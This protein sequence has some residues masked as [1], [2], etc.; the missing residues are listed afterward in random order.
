MDAAKTSGAT[1]RR[2]VLVAFDGSTSARLAARWAAREAA[3]S[4][5]PLQLAYVLRWPRP[6]L[7]GLRLPPAVLDPGQARRAASAVLDA[8]AAGCG[9]I[10]PQLDVRTELLTGGEVELLA[11]LAAG[12]HLLVLGACGQTAAPQVLLGSSAAELVRRVASSVVVVRDGDEVATPAHGHVVVGVDGSPG[13]AAALRFGFN[14]AARQGRV[15]VAVHA[16]SDLPL[17]AL[18]DPAGIDRVAAREDAAA[19]LAERLAAACRQEPQV[20]VRAVTTLDRPAHALLEQA[21][22]AALLVVGRHGRAAGREAPL[23]S[24]SHAV[25]HYASCPVAVVGPWGG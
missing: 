22:R 21:A 7:A 17:D 8:A 2:P 13:S 3:S 23:G 20:K 10:A 24:V 18:G 6:E 11:D 4:G 5:H 19:M 1:H 16:W 9:R 15:L 25:M 14:A 12:A